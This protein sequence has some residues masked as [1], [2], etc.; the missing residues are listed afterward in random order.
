MDNQQY[1]AILLCII[2][3]YLSGVLWKKYPEKSKQGIGE[4]H[5]VAPD[6]RQVR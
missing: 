2:D 1:P 6:G 5:E 3:G 4:H